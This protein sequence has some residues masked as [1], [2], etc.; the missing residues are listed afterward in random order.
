[1][2]LLLDE[3]ISP[4]V[5][6]S[7]RHPRLDEA[8]ALR[9]WQQGAYL[10]KADDVILRAAFADGI[11]LVT[12]DSATISPLLKVWGASGQAHAGVIFV[13]D[14]TLAQNDVGGMVRALMRVL[15]ALGDVS[16]ENRQ[17]YLRR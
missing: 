4:A 9:D 15:D 11:T 16:W 14:H 7:L 6:S 8:I 1:M 3:H 5:A 13:D 17:V 12:F 2:R 10:R